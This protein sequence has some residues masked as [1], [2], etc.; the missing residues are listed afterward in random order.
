MSKAAEGGM[1]DAYD[2]RA[3]AGLSIAYLVAVVGR[4]LC[5]VPL[6]VLDLLLIATVFNVNAAG[7]PAD[8]GGKGAGEGWVGV[9]RN[10]VSRALN[11]P[12]ETVRRRAAKLI[13][14]KVLREQADGLVFQPDNPVGPGENAELAAF[15]LEMLRQLF[16]GLKASGIKLD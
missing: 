2:G 16:R 9:S 7:A 1:A 15:N 5:T 11:V 4:T 3:A 12:L 6:D 14:N 8:K 13:K 10:A